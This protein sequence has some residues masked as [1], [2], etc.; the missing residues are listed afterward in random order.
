M[1]YLTWGNPSGMPLIW[2][3]GSLT[4]AYEFL[5]IA[6]SLVKAGY[7][8]IAI[9]YYGHGQTPIPE[10][11]VSL[12]HVADD[13][14]ALMDKEKIPKAVIGGWSRGGY[15]STAFYD[16]YPERVSGLILEDGGSV[17]TNTYYHKMDTAALSKR[18]DILFKDR[19]PDAVFNTEL[20]AYGACYDHQSQG[21]QFDLLAWIAQNKAGKWEIGP[22]LLALFNMQD[23]TRFLDNIMRPT[24]VPLFA[25]SM[26]ILEPKIVFRNLNVP[27]LILDPKS[28]DDLFPFEAENG[29]LKAQHPQWITHKIY[30]NTGHNIHYERRELFI[31]DLSAFYRK[32]NK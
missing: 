31:K 11:E 18:L 7:Y 10:H 22:G 23:R 3:H 12:Y 28:D 13:I 24:Q 29:Q 20:E 6:D 19:Y 21:S 14:R 4:N 8:V 25:E 1:H 9:D 2:S 5:T 16:T 26:A 17:A 32:L 27:V 30:E 15:I